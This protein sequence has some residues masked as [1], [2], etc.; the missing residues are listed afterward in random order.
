MNRHMDREV[1]RKA[2]RQ[3]PNESYLVDYFWLV[4]MTH[5]W[6]DDCDHAEHHALWWMVN[7]MIKATTVF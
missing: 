5:F 1:E 7:S 6:D 2:D 4:W 3:I